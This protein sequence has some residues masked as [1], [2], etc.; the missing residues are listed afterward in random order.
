[1]H[2]NSNDEKDRKRISL[3]KNAASVSRMAGYI[4]LLIV[5]IVFVA[6][7]I[8]LK[9]EHIVPWPGDITRYEFFLFLS[10]R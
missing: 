9:K 4:F 1:M 8:I 5:A 6:G 7:V 10:G 2:Q 3:L